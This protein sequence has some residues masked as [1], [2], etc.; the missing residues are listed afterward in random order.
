M[1]QFQ[2]QTI[3]LNELQSNRKTLYIILNAI[4]YIERMFINSTLSHEDY[5]KLCTTEMERFLRLFPFCQF[6][7]IAE[8]YTQLRLEKSFGY[9]RVMNGKPVLVEH[10]I[11][12]SGKLIIEITSNILTLINFDYMKIYDIQ[13]YIRLINLINIQLSVFETRNEEFENY[14]IQ[15]KE[16]E[17][18]LLKFDNSQSNS[19]LSNCS[20]ELVN[21]LNCTFNLFKE[22]NN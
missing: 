12:K 21:L 5:I 3:N 7:S 1:N 20:N 6:E 22:I 14:K 19:D 2:Q 10:K 18:K 13:E 16:W 15:L 17:N 9:Q 11:I 4:D 8:C